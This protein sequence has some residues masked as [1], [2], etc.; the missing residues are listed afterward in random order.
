MTSALYK[1]TIDGGL[2]REYVSSPA[3]ATL[4]AWRSEGK[5][6][7]FETDRADPSTTTASGWPGG[8]RDF[9]QRRRRSPMKRD[10][11]ET[12]MFGSIA[13]I[14][15]PMRDTH[16]LNMAE[17][18]DVNHLMRH[19]NLGRDIFVT[20]NAVSFID[21]GKREKLKSIL[22]ISVM[23]PDEVVAHIAEEQ[24]WPVPKAK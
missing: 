19:H 23:T 7:I 5:V 2:M 24:G 18:N 15:C 1:L 4:K 10:P 3:V 17:L 16:R 20:L 12:A 13:V 22:K 8:Q 6:E 21:A 9:S 11:K 14:I